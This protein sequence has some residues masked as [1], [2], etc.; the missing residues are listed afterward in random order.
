MARLDP[1]PLGPSGQFANVTR[2]QDT[3]GLWLTTEKV[4]YENATVGAVTPSESVIGHATWIYYED[5]PISDQL[6]W[7]LKNSRA[8]P[9][10]QIP[11]TRYDLN[12]GPVQGYRKLVENTGQV[13]SVTASGKVTYDAREG[14]SVVFW[15]VF[16]AWSDGTGSSSANGLFPVSPGP[17]FEDPQR[18]NVKSFS[19]TVKSVLE[20]YSATVKSGGS[21]GSNGTQTVTGTTGTGTKFQASVTVSG[22]AITAVLGVTVGGLYTVRP[23][24]LAAE[25]VTGASLTGATLSLTMD[26][27][28]TGSLSVAGG[29]ATQIHYE[30]VDEFHIKKVVEYFAI[31]GPLLRNGEHYDDELGK[32]TGTKQLVAT[33]S[34]V[35]AASS[36][37]RT[38]YEDSSYGSALIWAMVESWD[39]AAFPIKEEDVFDDVRSGTVRT[40]QVV[41]D[42]TTGGT[43]VLSGSSMIDTRFIPRDAF[44][45]LKV[46][47]TWPVPGSARTYNIVGRR[48]F[49][50]SLSR[51]LVSNS[52][53]PTTQ[54]ELVEVERQ[55]VGKNQVREEVTTYLDGSPI[56]RGRF[57]RFAGLDSISDTI[58]APTVVP[59]IA[60]SPSWLIQELIQEKEK[61][62]RLIETIIATGVAI[63]TI[64]R[65]DPTIPGARATITYSLVTA[66]SS[67]PSDSSTV[68]YERLEFPEHPLLRILKTT[69][70]DI[71]D[72]YSEYVDHAMSYPTLFESYYKDNIEGVTL[73][74]RGGF[75]VVVPHVVAHTFSTSGPTQV[76]PYQIIENDLTIFSAHVS[77]LMDAGSADFYLNGILYDTRSY[78][79]ST[80]SKSTYDGI[81]GD[82][83]T[84]GGGSEI[85]RAGIWHTK[86]ISAIVQ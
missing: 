34:Q 40:S 47:E 65:V 33:A 44:L 61:Q 66:A 42:L 49:I 85:Y 54:T 25:P 20:V 28:E 59:T 2:K 18:G 80:P 31:P 16:E 84:V 52:S 39:T 58:V 76:V 17:L 12:L 11:F 64:D 57:N 62:A 70:F 46:I 5:E 45:R 8:I 23:T 68:I 26:A 32:I 19:Q 7:R 48:G 6:V 37:G 29:I 10:A 38:R 81:I 60:T 14:S 22:G 41:T 35:Q 69:T 79:A 36:S 67:H 78:P 1:D 4:R 13:A 24:N 83:I 50:G 72:A 3:D 27:S 82:P 75:S 21:G 9:G 51:N 43:L 53:T 71:P 15:E 56:V 86:Y 63:D 30:Q 77:G 55:V 73:I 74:E